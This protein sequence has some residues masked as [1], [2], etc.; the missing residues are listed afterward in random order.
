ML[1]TQTFYNQ[2]GTYTVPADVYIDPASPAVS[3]AVPEAPPYFVP[4]TVN[5]MNI[6]NALGFQRY[7]L[8]YSN[9]QLNG[10]ADNPN[11][12]PPPAPKYWKFDPAQMKAYYAAVSMNNTGFDSSVTPDKFGIPG[13]IG[14]PFIP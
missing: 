1:K 5:T 7:C 12:T 6:D 9:Y 8:S 4:G 13:G 14:G 10:G 3:Q 2:F 11:L